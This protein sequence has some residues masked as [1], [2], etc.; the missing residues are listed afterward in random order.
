MKVK[1]LGLDFGL[2]R[3]GLA[4][5][6]GTLAS[7]FK[8]LEVNNFQDALG[9]VVELV[10]KEKIDRVVVGLPEGKISKTVIGFIKALK[11][12]GLD[13]E[14]ADETLSSQKA[15]QQMIESDISKK[16]RRVNDSVAAAIILQ[17]YLDSI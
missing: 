5:S 7:P 12:Q 17:D 2:K 13:V 6:E 1:Y 8:I 11:K 9:Q 10:S 4:I 3:V 14:S 15:L 16:G